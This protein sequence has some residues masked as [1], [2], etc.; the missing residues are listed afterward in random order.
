M[1]TI[2]SRIRCTA[3]VLSWLIVVGVAASLGVSAVSAAGP[4]H[5]HEPGSPPPPPEAGQTIGVVGLDG[6]PVLGPDGQPL[7]IQ[8]DAAPPPV[9]ANASEV[10]GPDAGP[11]TEDVETLSLLDAEA[12]TLEELADTMDYT[13]AERVD[14]YAENGLA[15]PTD[16]CPSGSPSC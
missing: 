3:L 1:T 15:A 4:A 7:E 6:Q 8:L 13:Q 16:P 5:T 12:R 2:R 11:P 14:F 9:P 10:L